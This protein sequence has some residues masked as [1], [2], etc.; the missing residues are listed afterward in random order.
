MKLERGKMNYKLSRPFSSVFM[1]AIAPGGDPKENPKSYWLSLPQTSEHD[2]FRNVEQ[3]K[4]KAMLGTPSVF[5]VDYRAQLI[6]FWPC[7]DREI[8]C[9]IRAAGE[10]FE[11]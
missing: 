9:S 8:P 1:V 7:P 3:S 4:D 2:I 6:S 11:D 10:V 5:A